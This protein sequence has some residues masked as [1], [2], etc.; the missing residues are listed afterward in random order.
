MKNLKLIRNAIKTPDGTL[1]ESLY[2]HDCKTYTDANGK[3]YTVDGGQDYQ[4][5]SANGD[6]EDACLYSDSSHDIQ[7]QVVTWGTY[8]KDGTE[9]YK[10]K[11]V[12]DMSNPHIEAVLRECSPAKHIADCMKKELNFRKKCL[13]IWIEN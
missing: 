3:T 12:A 4:R 6:E 11:K 9:D 1:L 2:R 7:R 8:G 13:D 5:R 10:R